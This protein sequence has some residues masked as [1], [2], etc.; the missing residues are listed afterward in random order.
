MSHTGRVVRLPL[1]AIAAL[2][3]VA[4]A[5]GAQPQPQHDVVASSHRRSVP[6]TVGTH[7][8]PLNGGVRCAEH[9]YPLRTKERLPVHPGGRIVLDFE[10]RPQEIDAQ[11]RDRRSR[12]VYELRTRGSGR[13]RTIRLPRRLPAGSDRL[14]F[15]VRYK[16]GDADFE[17]DLKRHR[18]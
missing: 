8:A 12:S 14:G 11:L 5:S 6:A 7:C 17:V 2:S 18:H 15:F 10:V 16:R 1:A 3:A 9:T 4:A 13:E